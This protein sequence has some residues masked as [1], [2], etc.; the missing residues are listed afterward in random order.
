MSDQPGNGKARNIDERLDALTMN[1]ELMSHTTE[2]N[3]RQI[4]ALGSKIDKLADA[5]IKLVEFSNR[6][7]T[8]I[9]ALVRIAEAH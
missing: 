7:A 2:E 8:D 3:S 6:D 9:S 1:L 4:A 5:V